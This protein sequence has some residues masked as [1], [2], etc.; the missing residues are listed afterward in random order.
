MLVP[1][2]GYATALTITL[3][4]SMRVH[5]TSTSCAWAPLRST[6]SGARRQHTRPSSGAGTTMT[7]STA[8]AGRCAA[9]PTHR[10]VPA[11]MDPFVLTLGSRRL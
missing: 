2:R 5:D 3:P 8:S 6:T 11:V 1:F 9:T 7:R 4:H 10:A